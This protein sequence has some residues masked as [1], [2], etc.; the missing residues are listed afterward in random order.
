MDRKIAFK[1]QGSINDVELKLI[2]EKSGPL[3]I[4]IPGPGAVFI[5]VVENEKQTRVHWN[6]GVCGQPVVEP[7]L[8]VKAVSDDFLCYAIKFEFSCRFGLF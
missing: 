8:M 5:Q 1:T 7:W 4:Q 6:L 3:V 2:A